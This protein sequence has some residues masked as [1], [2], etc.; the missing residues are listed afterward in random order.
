MA[1]QPQ[2]DP[3]NVLGRRFGAFFIDFVLGNAISIAF[4]AATKS[5]SYTGA[6]DEAC[7]RLRGAGGFSGTCIQMGSRVYTWES[8]R[9]LLGL[10]L[11]LG[12][13]FLNSVVLQGITGASVGK[14]ITGTR[15]VNAQGNVAGIGR[16]FVRW[17]LLIV[18]LFCAGLVG[19]ISVLATHPHRRVGDMVAGT[20][21][22]GTADVGNP[23]VVSAAPSYAYAAA[24]AAGGW[25]PP[26]PSQSGW[27]APPPAQPAQ[28]GAPPP[29]QQAPQPQQPGWGAP[30]AAAPQSSAW[31]PPPTPHQDQPRWGAPPPSAPPPQQAPPAPPSEE[32]AGWAAPQPA[33]QPQS[34]PPPAAPQPSQPQQPYVPPPPPSAPPPQSAPPSWGAPPTDPA[35]PSWGARPEPAPAPEPPASPPAQNSGESW[36]DK[37]VEEADRKDEPEG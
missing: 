19:L 25:A 5:A 10:V 33:Q 20:Y 12:V 24:P 4:L 9:Y 21:V 15:V 13:V 6:P 11:G 28:W 31:P 27:G 14:M 3:T 18:D 1:Y 37:G 32:Q 23:V 34:Y 36:W 17:L 8:G 2:R 30:P 35:P 26:Q 22:I 29:A 7:S 16:A